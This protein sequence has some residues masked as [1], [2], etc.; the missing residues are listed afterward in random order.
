MS[1]S[2]LMT[3]KLLSLVYKDFNDVVLV[4]YSNLFLYLKKQFLENVK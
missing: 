3:Y 2:Y 1:V 4:Y